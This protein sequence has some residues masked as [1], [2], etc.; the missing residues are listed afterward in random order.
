M[1]LSFSLCG[2]GLCFLVYSNN[3]L[4][5]SCLR[6]VCKSC[7]RHFLTQF[8]FKHSFSSLRHLRLAD[9]LG[10]LGCKLH[11]HTRACTCDVRRLWWWC[12]RK[13]IWRHLGWWHL[14]NC[15]TSFVV[16]LL[17]PGGTEADFFMLSVC[18]K[19]ANTAESLTPEKHSRKLL[20]HALPEYTIDC[21]E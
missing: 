15:L 7:F 8:T 6:L 20:K 19:Y 16:H 3:N 17:S 21:I 18:Q 2:T 13:V 1:A 9:G 14:P 4:K 12:L 10:E 5:L 11:F